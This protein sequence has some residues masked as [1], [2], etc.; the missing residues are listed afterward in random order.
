MGFLVGFDFIAAAMFFTW[1]Y[2]PPK[3]KLNRCQVGKQPINHK[4]TGDQASH[5]LHQSWSGK[6]RFAAR[7]PLRTARSCRNKIRRKNSTFAGGQFQNRRQGI[8]SLKNFSTH[9]GPKCTCFG[10]VTVKIRCHTA[11]HPVEGPAPTSH[12]A[13]ASMAL[14]KAAR[15]QGIH[16]RPFPVCMYLQRQQ[17]NWKLCFLARKGRLRLTRATYKKVILHEYH[18]FLEGTPKHFL[19]HMSMPCFVHAI[20]WIG[21]AVS[22]EVV[23]NHRP[24][25]VAD[26]NLVRAGETCYVFSF[27]SHDLGA[28]MYCQI[29]KQFWA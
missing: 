14:E 22:M 19:E 20:A 13:F 3:K 16:A 11:L 6:R 27:C 25:L 23:L 12:G 7:A 10:A 2:P 8:L 1:V 24:C 28:T 21:K 15:V 5:S 18:N 29:Q 4:L 17:K 9:I 26:P